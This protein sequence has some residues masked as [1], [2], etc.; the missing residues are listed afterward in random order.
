MLNAMCL[1]TQ[2]MFLWEFRKKYLDV[3]FVCEDGEK[4]MLQTSDA[5]KAPQIRELLCKLNFESIS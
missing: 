5:I 2:H 4:V 3:N 1:T